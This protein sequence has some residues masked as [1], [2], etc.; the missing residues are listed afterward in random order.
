MNHSSAGFDFWSL[1]LL[2]LLLRAHL[3]HRTR[4]LVLCDVVSLLLDFTERDFLVKMGV[5]NQDIAF[6]LELWKWAKWA[7]M[8]ERRCNRFTEPAEEEN[9]E[10]EKCCWAECCKKCFSFSNFTV[11]FHEL[12]QCHES[13]WEVKNISGKETFV[14]KRKS[15]SPRSDIF[16]CVFL[17]CEQV[18]VLLH[19]IILNWI[20]TTDHTRN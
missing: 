11:F 9:R 12:F 2:L 1:S 5:N 6:A 7:P 16:F 18:F 17:C 20:F 3:V 14:G 13:V 4:L 10:W 19:L 15:I 8:Y